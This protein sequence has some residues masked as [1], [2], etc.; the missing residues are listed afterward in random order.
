[1]GRM[2]IFSMNR[3]KSL[4]APARVGYLWFGDTQY[5]SIVDCSLI[6]CVGEPITSCI[7]DSV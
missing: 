5:S 7:T 6:G 2:V 1:M 4:K 3:S